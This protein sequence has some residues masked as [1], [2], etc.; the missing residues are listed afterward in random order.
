MLSSVKRLPDWDLPPDIQCHG[1][2]LR[3]RGHHWAYHRG[4]LKSKASWRWCFWLNLFFIPF[5]HRRGITYAWDD[6]RIIDLIIG[7]VVIGLAFCADQVYQGERATIPLRIL[8]NRTVG[9]GS[10]VK[11]CVAAAYV[12]LLYFLPIYFQSVQRSSAIRSGVQTLP[13]IM[14]VI[15]FM[16]A[17]GIMLLAGI[18]PGVAWMLPFIAASITLAP[19]DIK[20]GSVIVMF[21]QTLGGT[22]SVSIA[23]SC[24]RASSSSSSVQS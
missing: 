15:V 23:Q 6:S 10:L 13:L 14:A 21:F 16:T 1:C 19:E 2:S 20:L 11:F 8:K 3:Y 12:S 7:F 9:F 24:S 5:P 18:G 4:A 17:T 22:M